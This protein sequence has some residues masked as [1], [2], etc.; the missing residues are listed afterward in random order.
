MARYTGPKHRLARR[1][2]ANILDKASGSLGRRLSV[3]PGVHGPK[4]GRSKHSEYYLQ[5]REKQKAKR[6]YG[7]LEKQFRRYYEAAAKVPGKT[8]E[9]LLQNLERR[10]DNSVYRLGLVPSRAM[11]RQLVSHGHV[12]INGKKVNIPSYSLKLNE[13]VTLSPK[14]LEMP[15]VKKMLEVAE[16]KIPDYFEREAA[17]GRLV[18]IPGRDDIPT[19]VDEQLIIEFYS[20]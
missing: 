6:V 12:L 15:A 5:L 2:G 19:E 1:E 7:L 10:L 8:G 3:P 14:A 20:R 16:P 9:A 18:K 17:A 11:G 4:G 13:V